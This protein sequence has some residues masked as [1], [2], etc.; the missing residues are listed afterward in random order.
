MAIRAE[1]EGEVSALQHYSDYA[2][3]I[4]PFLAGMLSLVTAYADGHK[5]WKLIGTLTIALF[6]F[7][8]GCLGI[9]VR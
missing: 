2:K 9:F 4:T 1:G 7:V 8:V 3:M 6:F 5:S